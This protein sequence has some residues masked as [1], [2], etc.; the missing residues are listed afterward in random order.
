MPDP[1]NITSQS[2]KKSLEISGAVETR[3]TQITRMFVFFSTQLNKKNPGYIASLGER[4]YKF[5][6]PDNKSTPSLNVELA[7]TLQCSLERHLRCICSR[8][9]GSRLSLCVASGQVSP[10]SRS[11]KSTGTSSTWVR[12]Q[13]KKPSEVSGAVHAHVSTANVGAA[14]LF[15]LI[16]PLFISSEKEQTLSSSAN[17]AV[18]VITAKPLKGYGWHRLGG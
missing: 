11:S 6:F 5:Q 13:Q 18:S 8:C 12:H 15:T 9:P 10:W 7:Q 4:L 1:P 2:F 14:V 17:R 16:H 3:T